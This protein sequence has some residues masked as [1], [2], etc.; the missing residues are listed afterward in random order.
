MSAAICF[1]SESLDGLR[2]LKFGIPYV[3]TD[4][5]SGL[6]S[7][8]VEGRRV[9]SNRASSLRT[10]SRTSLRLRIRS[11]L[12]RDPGRSFKSRSK[13]KGGLPGTNLGSFT[14]IATV[15]QFQRADS[16]IDPPPA[17]GLYLP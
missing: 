15:A 14:R 6:A 17:Q 5:S 9:F 10:D 11:G 16:A 4:C 3:I 8:P 2:E 1:R 12:T 7:G 13:S